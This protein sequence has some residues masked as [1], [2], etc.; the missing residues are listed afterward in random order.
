MPV[1]AMP[2][3]GLVV[4]QTEF[5]LGRLEAVLD[6]PA[7]PFNLDQGSYIGPGRAPGREKGKLPIRKAAADQ[8]APCPQA[9]S[10]AVVFAGF[11]IGQLAVNPV[12]QP[13]AL[14]AIA[15]RQTLP[16]RS[17][18][19]PRDLRGR[20][21]PDGLVAPGVE[22]IGGVGAQHIALAGPSQRHLDLTDPI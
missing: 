4:I 12:V 1:P 11:Q 15:R 20:T 3:P 18:E 14:A 21:G 8:K 7:M 10:G 19:I 17:L 6:G 13:G 5:R 16:S 22:Q 9:G 2:G